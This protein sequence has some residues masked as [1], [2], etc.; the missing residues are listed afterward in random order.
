MPDKNCQI[1]LFVRVHD[2]SH[3]IWQMFSENSRSQAPIVSFHHASWP[4]NLLAQIN[5]LKTLW[6][7]NTKW[8]S[9]P[10]YSAWL[11]V[12]L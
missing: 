4:F 3:K 7:V 1:Q 10:L 11:F 12:S 8:F 2:L 9:G 5:A 6:K